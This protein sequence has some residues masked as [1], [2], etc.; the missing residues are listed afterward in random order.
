MLVIDTGL[1]TDGACVVVMDVATMA[2]AKFQLLN[3]LIGDGGFE[4]PWVE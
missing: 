3:F 2:M 1:H 4:V